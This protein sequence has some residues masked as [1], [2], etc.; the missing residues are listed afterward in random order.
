MDQQ[1]YSRADMRLAMTTWQT[2]VDMFETS[3]WTRKFDGQSPWR[4]LEALSAIANGDATV[5]TIAGRIQA[6]AFN[7]TMLG[8]ALFD[9]F[10]LPQTQG[11]VDT[12]DLV[13]NN[14]R[15][16]FNT[17]YANAADNI[18]KSSKLPEP[19]FVHNCLPQNWF[20]EYQAGAFVS[21]GVV[22]DYAKYCTGAAPCGLDNSG[23]ENTQPECQGY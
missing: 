10:E 8:P 23:L 14:R 6:R 21:T 12:T 13:T 22:A 2:V 16:L 19:S 4:S 17:E 11:P 18:P 20:I 3:G 9:A 1:Y 15:V 5:T 7:A